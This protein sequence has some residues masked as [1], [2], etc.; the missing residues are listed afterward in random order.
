MNEAGLGA[1]P[2]NTRSSPGASRSGMRGLFCLDA[3][4]TDDLA[5]AR[6]LGLDESVDLGDR[7]VAAGLEAALAH[8]GDHGANMPIPEIDA[9]IKAEYQRWGEVIRA[10]GIKPE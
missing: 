5:P 8:A 6:V 10:A 7:H 4:G 9:F 1:V 2:Q 3:R